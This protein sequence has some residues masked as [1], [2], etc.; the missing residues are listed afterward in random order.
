MVSRL[1]RLA[2]SIL[3]LCHISAELERRHVN[4]RVIDQSI[5]TSDVTGRLLFNMVGAIAQFETEI[6]VE[7]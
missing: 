3:H 7:R 5:D 4:L 6:W 1:D 2:R